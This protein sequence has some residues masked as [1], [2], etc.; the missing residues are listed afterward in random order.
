[1]DG[2]RAS[3]QPAAGHAALVLSGR[4]RFVIESFSMSLS[5]SV[6]FGWTWCSRRRSRS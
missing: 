3:A 6:H 2:E 1:L 4:E 5:M